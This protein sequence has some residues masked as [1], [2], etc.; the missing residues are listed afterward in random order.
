MMFAEATP[1]LL[2]PRSVIAVVTTSL[3]LV[4][5]A[6]VIGSQPTINHDISRA[7]ALVHKIHIA[8]GKY[9]DYYHL[10]FTLTPENTKLAIPV[11]QDSGSKN[12]DEFMFTSWGQFQIFIPKEMFPIE[13]PNCKQYIILR[14]PWTNPSVP[15]SDGYIVEK[16]S[17]FQQI[18]R[19]KT[20]KNVTTDV[21]IELNP[22]VAVKN[23]DP[24]KV[25][26][27]GCN[28][29]FRHAHGRYI[30]YLGPLKKD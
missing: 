7:T 21:I 11:A 4:S 30:D 28:V 10:K 3:F 26:L 27:T 17:L 2:S 22:Y 20:G 8:P 19:L 29:F 15:E 23:K 18:R 25:E 12:S 9:S 6:A 14:M 16:Q 1:R 5:A 13:A 24:L